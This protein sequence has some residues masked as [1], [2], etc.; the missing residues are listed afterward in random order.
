[1]DCNV[2]YICSIELTVDLVLLLQT[3]Y[4]LSELGVVSRE[5]APQGC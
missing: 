5:A 3:E 1:M 2:V 4:Y